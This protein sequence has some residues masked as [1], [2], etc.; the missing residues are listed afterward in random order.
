MRSALLLLLALL[1][2]NVT[3]AERVEKKHAKD[4]WKD[5]FADPT[6]AS[7]RVVILMGK[8]VDGQTTTLHDCEQEAAGRRKKG[9]HTCLEVGCPATLGL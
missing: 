7:A 3:Q 6:N 5:L 4:L 9:T 8:D 2:V 1:L